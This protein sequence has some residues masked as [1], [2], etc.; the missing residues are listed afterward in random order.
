MTGLHMCALPHVRVWTGNRSNY[1]NRS[2]GVAK[3]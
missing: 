1:S 3:A 2:S